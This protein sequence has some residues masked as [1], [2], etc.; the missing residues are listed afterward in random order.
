M[1]FEQVRVGGDRNFAYVIG[2]P[3]SLQGLV[4]DPAF[5]PELVLERASALGLSIALLVNTHGHDDHVNGNQLVLDRTGAEL[6]GAWPGSTRDGEKRTLGSLQLTFI[7]TPG[8][9]ADSMCLLVEGPAGAGKL[10]TGD[11]LFVGKVGGTGFG[12]D[13]RAEY[14]SLREKLLTLPD[15]VEVYPGHDYGVAPS[16][17][18]GSERRTNPFLLRASLDDFIDLKRNWQAYKGEHGIK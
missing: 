15:E 6:L 18:I 12:D 3:D 9:T 4:V 8:H 1:I 13:A 7:H 2:D 16:S 5:R 10:M 11:T 14:D 17:T